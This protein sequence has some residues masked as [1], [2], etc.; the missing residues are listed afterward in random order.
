MAGKRVIIIGSKGFIGR[1]LIKG[2]KERNSNIVVI[3]LDLPE[4]DL[5]LADSVEKM[6]GVF[7][8]EDI[9]VMLAGIKRQY[10]DDL[11]KFGKNLSMVTNL[12]KALHKRPVLRLIY[13]SSAAVYGEDIHN[14][15]IV[16]DSPVMP[17]SYYGMAKYM[18][19][20]LL[21]KVINGQE[22]S[23]LLILRPPSIY[24]PGDRSNGYGPVK[25]VNNLSNNEEVV[26]WGD[27]SELREFLNISDAVEIVSRLIFSN[28]EG[29]VN[30]ASGRS[31]SFK[32]ILSSLEKITGKKIDINIRQ[33]TKEKVDNVFNNKKLISII[34]DYSF[35]D[36]S[37]GLMSLHKELVE[38]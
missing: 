28:R 24:G 37:Q 1:N 36:I 20:R 26:L 5:T 7:Q 30:L 21:W 38:A 31:Y 29:V 6:S 34:G 13:F 14:T 33:R 8:P 22:N 15:S 32:D 2:L 27:G 9:I 12:S 16:E 35:I 10:G 3:E 23:S 19:E 18:G 17:T 25:F 4:F 11:L